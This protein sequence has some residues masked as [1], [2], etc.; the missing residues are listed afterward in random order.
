MK[1]LFTR[2]AV[3]AGIFLLCVVVSGGCGESEEQMSKKKKKKSVEK[4]TVSKKK[5]GTKQI[6]VLETNKGVIKFKFYSKDAPE[7]VKNFIKLAK[8][9]FY[10]GLT[11]HRVVAGFVIQGGCPEGTGRGGPGYNIKAEFNEQNH[12]EGSVAMARSMDPDSAGSQFYIC[13]GPQPGL[14][15]KYT[16]FGQV[17]EGLEVVHEI[18]IGDVMKKVYVE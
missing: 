17:T 3:A 18:A 9:G 5:Q 13:L 14:D 11:F 2:A 12:L 10:D 4:T 16:V 8:K 15:G 1:A 6:A 7:T